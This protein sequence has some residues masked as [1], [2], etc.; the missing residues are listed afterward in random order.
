MVTE[1]FGVVSSLVVP[2]EILK[3]SALLYLP[4]GFHCCFV[5]FQRQQDR[6][7]VL[8]REDLISTLDQPPPIVAVIA[9]VLLLV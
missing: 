6:Q 1:T 3:L 2:H 5:Y 4:L 8:R 7:P 9:S